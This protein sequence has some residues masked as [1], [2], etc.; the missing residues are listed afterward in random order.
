M[1]EDIQLSWWWS[2]SFGPEFHPSCK[3][4]YP[5]PLAL[6]CHHGTPLE[7]VLGK[8]PMRTK[9]HVGKNPMRKKSQRKKSYEDKIPEEEIP[10]GQN[11]RG[12]NP[13]GQNPRGQNPKGQNPIRKKS[14]V[15][16]YLKRTKSHKEKKNTRKYSIVLVSL[17]YILRSQ[18]SKFNVKNL[19]IF[20]ITYP[21]FAHYLCF[22]FIVRWRACT[23]LCFLIKLTKH[24]GQ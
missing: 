12:Q 18:F 11:P 19:R 8:N 10:W 5:A 14:H 24:H 21:F 17:E 23:R 7:G 1:E 15:G 13:R 2:V 9:S 4:T 20:F 6:S 22:T 16:K 3:E